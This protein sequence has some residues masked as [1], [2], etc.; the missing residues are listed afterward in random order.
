MRKWIIVL[1]AAVLVAAAGVGL[2]SMSAPVLEE[3]VEYQ[4]TSL[5]YQGREVSDQVDWDELQDVLRNGSR[6]LISRGGLPP[7]SSLELVEVNL[8]GEKG[9]LHV[10]LSPGD[11]LYAAYEDADWYYVLREGEALSSAVQALLPGQ[12]EN[13][14]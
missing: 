8:Q 3:D 10:V 4:L 12:A 11:G 9:A 13:Q 7:H 2:L 5:Y 14:E 6:S 1:V